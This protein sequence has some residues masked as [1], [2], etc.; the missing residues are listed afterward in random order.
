MILLTA[1]LLNLASAANLPPELAKVPHEKVCEAIV[2]ASSLSPVSSLELLHHLVEA[3]WLEHKTQSEVDALKLERQT[4]A[5]D[6]AESH[7]LKD[8]GVENQAR[9]MARQKLAN[10]GAYYFWSLSWL[11]TGLAAK[12]QTALNNLRAV[13]AQNESRRVELKPKLE[14][15]DQLGREEQ[16]RY[17]VQSGQYIRVTPEGWHVSQKLPLFKGTFAGK[18]TGG[19]IVLVNS[20]DAVMEATTEINRQY[21]YSRLVPMLN[22][23]FFMNTEPAPF[24]KLVE[25]ILARD[26]DKKAAPSLALAALQYKKKPAEVE[27]RFLALNQHSTVRSKHFTAALVSLSFRYQLDAD[28]MLRLVTEAEKLV[29]SGHLKPASIPS[30]ISAHLSAGN[31]MSQIHFLSNQLIDKLSKDYRDQAPGLIAAAIKTNRSVDDVASLVKSFPTG[32]LY[33]KTDAAGLAILAMNTGLPSQDVLA[34][35]NYVRSK[36]HRPESMRGTVAAMALGQAI[37]E[38]MTRTREEAATTVSSTDMSMPA[39]DPSLFFPMF[40]LYSSVD[41]AGQGTFDTND[42]VQDLASDIGSAMTGGD[43]SVGGGG[44]I[45][46]DYSPPADF[47]GGGNFGGS[48]FGGTF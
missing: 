14:L 46:G 43:L 1:F 39:N 29:E 16:R 2:S 44:T 11:G 37:S 25:A 8:I 18:P 17:E 21:G 28:E 45:G 35:Y 41:S 4:L 34:V 7:L 31:G 12:N 6:V 19:L 13:H 24:E 38:W 9:I 42:L 3:G 30:L 32:T 27:Q 5:R 48:D 20:L 10:S 22:A 40:L 33:Q 15:Y 26:V 36:H 47:G 23:K